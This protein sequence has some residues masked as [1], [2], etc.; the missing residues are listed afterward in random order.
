MVNANLINIETVRESIRERM[1]N[2]EPAQTIL[3]TLK[4]FE[5]KR[6]NKNILA[7]VRAALPKYQVYISHSCGW[8]TLTARKEGDE[9]RIRLAD[10]EKN[11]VVDTDHIEKDNGAHYKYLAERN[12]ER[13]Q[14]LKNEDLLQRVADEINNYNIQGRKLKSVLDE[15]GQRTGIEDWIYKHNF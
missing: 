3:K 8:S 7:A 10:H 13:K 2:P 4:R 1:E 11:V 5:G 15:L 6:W 9:T 14:L 12:E